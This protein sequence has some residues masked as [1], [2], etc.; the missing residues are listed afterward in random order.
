MLDMLGHVPV[1]R[2][3]ER[4]AASIDGRKA[5]DSSLRINVVLSDVGETWVL[6]IENAVLHFRRG[7]PDAAASATLTLTKPLFI[8]VMTGLATA[9]DL[10]LSGEAT[11]VGSTLDVGRFLLLI[12]RAPGTFPI[13]A[14]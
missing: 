11:V 10:L 12:E 13:V 3:L 4:L 5:A 6:W 9:T 2:F 7:P 14:P 8:R 1:E